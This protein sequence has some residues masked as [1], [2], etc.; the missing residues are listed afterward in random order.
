[1][2]TCTD[3]PRCWGVGTLLVRVEVLGN[4]ASENRNGRL[5]VKIEEIVGL[6]VGFSNG[7]NCFGQRSIQPGSVHDP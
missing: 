4:E 3:Y 6:K 1:M 5:S 2:G 7:V